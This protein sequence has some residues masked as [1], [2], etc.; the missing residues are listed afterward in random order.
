MKKC[1]VVI[2][3]LALMFAFCVQAV[4]QPNAKAME[5]IVLENFDDPDNAE[6]EWKVQASRFVSKE[7]DVQYPIINYFTG[8]S[9][10][11]VPYHKDPASAKVLGVKAKFDRKGE[12]W[13]EVYPEYKDIQDKNGNPIREIPLVGTLS[14]LDFW[15][16]GAH[17]QYYLEV[18]LRDAAGIVHV[19]PVGTM[20]FNGWRN[21]IVP[22]SGNILQ[23]SPMR[24]G[25]KY[26]ALMGFRVRADAKENV[27]DFTIYFDQIKYTTNSLDNVYDGF[28]LRYADFGDGDD[29]SGTYEKN[30]Q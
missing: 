26:L 30:K 22:I 13:F 19:I 21:F 29:Y 15:V 11:L 4:A 24:S 5:T 1:I 23:H 7:G 8:I 2:A 10:S 27:D 17:Y 20:N 9:N 18:L 3:S 28:S 6:W 25:P 12:N 16:W 14:Q